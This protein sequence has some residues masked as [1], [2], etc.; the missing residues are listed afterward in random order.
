MWSVLLSLHYSLQS[1]EIKV[2]ADDKLNLKPFTLNMT[3][4]REVD[5]LW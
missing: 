3:P 1:S 5:F 2:D 4:G